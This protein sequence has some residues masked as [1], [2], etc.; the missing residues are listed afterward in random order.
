[1]ETL[2][3][4]LTLAGEQLENAVEA[5]AILQPAEFTL[6]GPSRTGSRPFEVLPPLRTPWDPKTSTVTAQPLH[7]ADGGGSGALGGQYGEPRWPTPMP[8]AI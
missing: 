6:F 8:Q 2:A 1:M 4:S 3:Q 7:V 5:A